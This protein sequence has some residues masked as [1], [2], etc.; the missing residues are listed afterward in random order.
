MLDLVAVAQRLAGHERVVETSPRTT[1]HLVLELH[2][3]YLVTLP[4]RNEHLH[5]TV[6]QDRLEHPRRQEQQEEDRVVPCPE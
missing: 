6:E 2:R 4:P 3:D 1:L 5:Q